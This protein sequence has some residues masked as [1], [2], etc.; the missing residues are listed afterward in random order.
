MS[1]A[2]FDRD[3]EW[4]RNFLPAIRKHVGPLL[5]QEAPLDL[6]QS[7]ATDFLLMDARDRRIA[8]RVRREGYRDQY[9]RQVTFRSWRESG[10]DTGWQKIV[11][12]GYADWFFYGHYT[13]HPWTIEPWFVIDLD[14][15]RSIGQNID[16]WRRLA[17]AWNKPNGNDGGATRFHAFDLRSVQEVMRRELGLDPSTLY[18]GYSNFYGNGGCDQITMS[19]LKDGR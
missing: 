7:E 14:V 17:E 5:V 10:V 1:A 2:G 15:F 19:V 11:Q 3:F 13:G 18:V 8:A 6:D 9:G 4:Q 16:S 12:Q